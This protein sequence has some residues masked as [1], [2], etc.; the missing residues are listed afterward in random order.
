MV[1]TFFEAK[2]NIF[3]YA[4]LK[5]AFMM[6]FVYKYNPS[7]QPILILAPTKHVRF[8][9]LTTAATLDILSLQW[10]GFN[11]FFHFRLQLLSN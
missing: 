1:L 9:P 7:P 5:N 3:P 2:A 4:A 11:F 10:I 8:N 6:Y